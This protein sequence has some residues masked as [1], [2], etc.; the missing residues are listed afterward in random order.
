MFGRS[1]HTSLRV[2]SAD[3]P[4]PVETQMRKEVASFQLPQTI[5][6]SVIKPGPDGK[7]AYSEKI[8][9]LASEVASLTLLETIDLTA[10][11]KETLGITDND[12]AVGFGG[13]VVSGAPT[14]V[15]AAP[16]ASA[17]AAA[18][19]PPAPKEEKPQ[20]DIKLKSFDAASKIKIIKAVRSITNLGL[21]E[22]KDLVESAPCTILANVKREDAVKMVEKL[23]AEVPADYELV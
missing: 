15:A 11:L 12:L 1:L 17:A 14:S 18:A 3:R 5:D 4:G 22:A 6:L 23:K 10:V 16:A 20:V 2:L 19:A 7:R 13:G 21:K 8:K 9:R